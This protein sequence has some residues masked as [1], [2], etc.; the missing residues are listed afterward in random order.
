M[1]SGGVFERLQVDNDDRTVLECQQPFAFP[2]FQLPIDALARNA[3]LLGETFLTDLEDGRVL[4]T[5]A[6]NHGRETHGQPDGQGVRVALAAQSSAIRYLLQTRRVIANSTSGRS[7]MI[8]Q[9]AL[10]G[11][12]ATS[13]EELARTS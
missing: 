11:S 9:N 1:F 10:A 13:T 6:M 2:E 8:C 4:A 12:T 3:Q 7:S 5:R